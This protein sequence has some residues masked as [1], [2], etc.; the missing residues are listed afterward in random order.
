MQHFTASSFRI[1]GNSHWNS[2][3]HYFVIAGNTE[4]PWSFIGCLANGRYPHCE[5]L[6]HENLFCTGIFLSSLLVYLHCWVNY[7]FILCCLS[8]LVVSTSISFSEGLQCSNH[9]TTLYV[10]DLLRSFSSPCYYYHSPLNAYI[11][12]FLFSISSFLL[13]AIWASSGINT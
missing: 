2:T 11:F 10:T 7:S 1:W 12:P 5:P 3:F 6:G 9:F 4:E 13:T 8:L